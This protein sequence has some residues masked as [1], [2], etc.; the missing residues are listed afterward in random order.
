VSGDAVKDNWEHGDA[1]E[2]F[3]GRWS[4]LVAIDFLSWLEL[5]AGL[6]WV[7]VGCGT[8][9]LSEAILDGQDPTSVVGVEPSAGF[10]DAA[11]ERLGDRA[12]VHEAPAE[13]LPLP[14]GSA[15]IVVSGLVLNFIRDLPTALAEMTRVAAGGIVA[16]YVWD[17]SGGMHMLRLFWEAA[18]EID[19]H[20]S[21]DEGGRFPICHPDALA[22]AFT[23]AGMRDP[24]VV[25]IDVP[26][27]FADFDELWMPFTGG[28]GAGPSYLVSLPERQQ[29][30]LKESLRRRV[31]ANADGSISLTARAWAIRASV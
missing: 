1:Y 3:I 10:V 14:E 22:A 28:Q 26:T 24:E 30:A 13:S 20:G 2:R 27:P 29:A 15:D 11:R 17:Y 25:P 7:D 9:A 16:A 31:P 5:P 6:R 23:A 12:T 19:P 18:A 4:S 8:G 21:V